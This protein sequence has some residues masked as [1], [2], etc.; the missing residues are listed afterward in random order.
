MVIKP[1]AAPN[2]AANANS[3]HTE[4]ASANTENASGALANTTS[5][6]ARKVQ[7]RPIDANTRRPATCAGPIH[8]T[9]ASASPCV[10]PLDASAGITC[11]HNAAEA[12]AYSVNASASSQNVRWRSASP[13]VRVGA[14]PSCDSA[15]SGSR[16][17]SAQGCSGSHHH[18]QRAGH[19]QQRAAPAEQGSSHATAGNDSVL[20]KPPTS[21]SAVMPWR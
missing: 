10:K 16:P 19:R 8:T 7:R 20:A 6:S 5:P 1:L 12:N 18:Q 13:S 4:R 15:S 9:T 11:A 17:R 14:G 3:V 21:V 2:N